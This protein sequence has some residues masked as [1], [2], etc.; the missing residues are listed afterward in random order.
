M[1]VFFD[2]LTMH[3]QVILINSSVDIIQLQS[4]V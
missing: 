3:H 4:V 2:Y 1:I